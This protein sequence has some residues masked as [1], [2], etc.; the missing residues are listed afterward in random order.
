MKNTSV[1][2]THCSSAN[3]QDDNSEDYLN[4]RTSLPIGN[5]L[6]DDL[7]ITIGDE[8]NPTAS[9]RMEI[10]EAVPL[11]EILLDILKKKLS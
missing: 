2:I 9:F 6:I 3:D 5:G 10:K 1:S 8:D 7:L 4:F 11:F